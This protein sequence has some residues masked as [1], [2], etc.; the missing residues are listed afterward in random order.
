[1]PN[2][3]LL[4]LNMRGKCLLNGLH[5]YHIY[6]L[7]SVHLSLLPQY[8]YFRDQI[9]MGPFGCE[10]IPPWN[11]QGRLKSTA[12]VCKA[13]RKGVSLNEKDTVLPCS[14]CA[15]SNSEWASTSNNGIGING[16]RSF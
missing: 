9:E 4:V 5:I 3:V 14:Y 6:S 1:M 10:H 15:S 2:S 11:L 8:T 7:N 12:L 16:K 13:N